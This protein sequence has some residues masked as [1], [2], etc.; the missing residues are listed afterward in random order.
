MLKKRSKVCM[1]TIPP[2]ILDTCETFACDFNLQRK[3]SAAT[4]ECIVVHPA[5][6]STS[7]KERKRKTDKVDALRLALSLVADDLKDTK[8]IILQRSHF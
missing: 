5:Y 7:D 1:V 4:M 8:E 2:L 6:V 3:L